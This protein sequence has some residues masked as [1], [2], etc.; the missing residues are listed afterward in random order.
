MNRLDRQDATGRSGYMPG[1]G[2]TDGFP[3]HSGGD[4]TAGTGV[5]LNGIQ[6]FIPG[7]IFRNFLGSNGTTLYVN[8][9]TFASAT[10]LNI[11]GTI[12]TLVTNVNPL[13][14]TGVTQSV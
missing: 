9:G 10:W 14:A 6:G 13:L 8:V 5:P 2:N 7:A 3:M 11:D 1:R 4:F 12:N